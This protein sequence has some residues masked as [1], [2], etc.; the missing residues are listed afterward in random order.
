MNRRPTVLRSTLCPAQLLGGVSSG[1]R[2]G[3]PEPA[4]QLGDAGQPAP[5]PT[6]LIAV[7][8]DSGSVTS[9][10]GNDPVA[11]RYKEMERA[12][13]SVAQAGVA[14]EFGAVVHF[15]VGGDADVAPVRLTGRGLRR[16]R[17]GLRTPQGGAGSS[18]LGPSLRRAVGLADSYQGYKT[19]LVVLSDFELL[20]P[21]P[22]AI[23]SDLAVFPGEVHAVVLGGQPHIALLDDRIAVT[24]VRPGDAPG[25]VARALF[26]SLVAHRPGSL[27][28]K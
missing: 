7:S 5:Y 12:F 9:S 13:V 18:E 4:Y 16:L 15:D 17:R 25:A 24:T 10:G 21:D 6:L 26:A 20:D 11:A 22:R 19:T 8:D 2:I 27:A 14:R 1:D 23:L 28:S 3:L